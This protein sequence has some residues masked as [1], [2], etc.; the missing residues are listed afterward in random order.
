MEIRIRPGTKGDQAVIWSATT[1]TVWN[2]LP[3]A[4]RE[5]TDRRAFEAHFRPRAQRIME[6]PENAT[7][8]AE[9]ADGPVVGYVILGRAASML[10]PEPYG[11]VYDLWVSPEARRQ[12]VGRHLLDRAADWCR[13]RGLHSLRLEVGAGNAPAR[14]LYAAVGFA[15]ERVYLGKRV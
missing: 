13:E 14:A 4:E 8:V 2:D 5:G 7:L 10:G 1:E 3:A 15:E 12:G 9:R 11:L 6:S